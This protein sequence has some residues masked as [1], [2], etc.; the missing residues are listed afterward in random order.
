MQ[1]NMVLVMVLVM[2]AAVAVAGVSGALAMTT[3]SLVT[4]GQER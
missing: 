2:Q 1:V 3:P 4:V